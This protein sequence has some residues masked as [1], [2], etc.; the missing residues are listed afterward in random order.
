M[1][2]I[3]QMHHTLNVINF[4]HI[5]IV[6][7]TNNIGVEYIL[8][9]LMRFAIFRFQTKPILLNFTFKSTCIFDISTFKIQLNLN[10]NIYSHV[11]I[12]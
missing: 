3:Y 9:V 1:Y 6:R 5:K 4:I 12:K 2:Y 8:M 7:P 10:Q 11:H